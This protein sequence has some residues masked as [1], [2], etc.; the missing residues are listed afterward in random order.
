MIAGFSMDRCCM[1]L[2]KVSLVAVAVRTIILTDLWSELQ[3][4]PIS[5]NTL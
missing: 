1:A 2:S 4:L 3:M 5:A